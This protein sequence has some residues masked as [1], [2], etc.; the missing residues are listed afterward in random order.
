MFSSNMVSLFNVLADLAFQPNRTSRREVGSNPNYAILHAGVI[1]T[2]YLQENFSHLFRYRTGHPSQK[3][4]RP[5]TWKCDEIIANLFDSRW[6]L[7]V[8]SCRQW[9]EPGGI[10][11]ILEKER[12]VR[13]ASFYQAKCSIN[14]VLIDR[15]S[16]RDERQQFI[17]IISGKW[18]E[19]VN[20]RCSVCVRHSRN[21]DSSGS[22]R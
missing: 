4:H 18:R 1:S 2:T 22:H 21:P 19:K 13:P 7:E 10:Q 3:S 14:V 20:N 5:P 12:E 15:R 17:L 11:K 8:A 6:L 16:F 9:R